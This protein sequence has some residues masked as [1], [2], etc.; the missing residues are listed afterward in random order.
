MHQIT[1]YNEASENI[2]SQHAKPS[3]EIIEIIKN[4]EF[5]KN[6]QLAYVETIGIL[7]KEAEHLY[8]NRRISP[9]GYSLIRIG[10]QAKYFDN[11]QIAWELEYDDRG[12]LIITGKPQYR[13]D[14]TVIVY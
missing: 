4:E 13:R 2:K 11:G 3:S 1:L 5:H 12:E 14:G 8:D 7:S 9:E 6:G 10:R